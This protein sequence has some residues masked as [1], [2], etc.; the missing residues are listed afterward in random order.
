MLR[1]RSQWTGAGEPTPK[2]RSAS[3][4]KRCATTRQCMV[5][6]IADDELNNGALNR[7][8]RHDG[9][10]LAAAQHERERVRPTGD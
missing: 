6:G 4:R 7:Q 1:D 3:S 5:P 8:G 2:A 10:L 9:A